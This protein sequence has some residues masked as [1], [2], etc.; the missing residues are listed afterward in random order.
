MPLLR[1]VAKTCALLLI[2]SASGIL[3][4]QTNTQA[5]SAAQ[6]SAAQTTARSHPVCQGIAPFYWEIGNAQGVAA[7]EALPGAQGATP[8]SALAV[9]PLASGSKWLYAAYVVEQREGKLSAADIAQLN[10]TS[11]Y[12]S[13]QVRCEANQSA[14]ACL[15]SGT[16]HQHNADHVGKFFY[17]S[18]HMQH[19]VVEQMQLGTA[20]NQL[21]TRAMRSVLGREGHFLQPLPAGGI[22]T[23]PTAYGQF[24]QRL[25]R[26]ELALGRMLGQHKVCASP[27]HCPQSAVLT[28][29]PPA[30]R[31]SYALG[32]WVEDGAGLDGAFSSPGLFGFY[33][34]IDA[35]Q[36]SYGLIARAS[37]QGMRAAN[38]DQRP[39]AQSMYCARAMRKALASGNAVLN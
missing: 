22:A 15:R 19:H 11:G 37:L 9:L 2:A 4:A 29:F 36:T 34:W 10:F 23:T 1:G 17:G 13:G 24:L 30:E 32:H 8:F 31:V 38:V 7:S 14:G 33:P 12:T 3:F 5:F 16:H 25:L 35:A 28:A 21:L 20:D 6:L 39:Y 26:G 18:G 27:S